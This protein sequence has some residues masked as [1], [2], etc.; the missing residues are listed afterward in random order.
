MGHLGSTNRGGWRKG[1]VIPRGPEVTGRH[2]FSPKGSD[3]IVDRMWVFEITYARSTAL[4]NFEK[5][6]LTFQKP[7]QLGSE[8]VAISAN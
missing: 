3:D 1:A 2:I 6:S 4:E 8:I 7:R 5:Y